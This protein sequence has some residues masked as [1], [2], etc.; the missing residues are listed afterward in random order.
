MLCQLGYQRAQ[1]PRRP[2]A[3]RPV[4]HAAA[5]RRDRPRGHPRRRRRAS[6]AATARRGRSF[7]RRRRAPL[8]RG[9]LRGR[10]CCSRSR[11]ISGRPTRSRD[12]RSPR[13][14][15][16]ARRAPA[17]LGPAARRS[18]SSGRCSRSSRRGSS[19]NGPTSGARSSLV[20]RVR[21][22]RRARRAGGSPARARSCSAALAVLVLIAVAVLARTAR[23]ARSSRCSACSSPRSSPRFGR[24][25][26]RARTALRTLALGSALVVAVTRLTGYFGAS[27]VGATWFGGGVVHGPRDSRRGRDH[28]RRRPER[29]RDARDHA[30][31]RR[32]AREGIVLRRRQDARRSRRRSCA[33][34]YADGQ[35]VGNHSYHHDDWRWLDPRYPE[36][37]RTQQAFAREIGT[38]PVWFRPP[39]GQRTPLMARVVKDHG[40]RMAMWDVSTATTATDDRDRRSRDGAARRCGAGR[41]STCTTASTARRR[42]PGGRRRRAAR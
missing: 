5:R 34:S 20:A 23:L 37:E 9:V 27:T 31:P 21:R 30:D 16:S 33:T 17:P 40:M 38:C 36:L 8:D 39:H 4:A 35:L 42:A 41:S 19:R 32:R 1:R 13:S 11:S 18:R 10:R 3:G 28:L 14:P 22:R 15:R 26:C 12:R 25:A 2:G 29:Q 24:S 6:G 7:G